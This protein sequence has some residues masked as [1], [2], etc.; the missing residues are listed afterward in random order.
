VAL[1]YGPLIY[2]IEAVDQDISQVLGPG[3]VLR[4]EWRQDLLGG[5]TVVRG[6]FAAGSPMTAIPYY[7]RNNRSP[8]PGASVG[9][10]GSRVWVK[11]Q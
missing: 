7:A 9:S 3:S 2:S 6:V 11:D 4:A 10:A 5:V 8:R 1:R